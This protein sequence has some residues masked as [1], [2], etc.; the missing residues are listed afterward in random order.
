MEDGRLQD[1]LVSWLV[2]VYKFVNGLMPTYHSSTFV[3]RNSGYDLRGK[4]ITRSSEIEDVYAWSKFLY[5]FR[6]ESL[7]FTN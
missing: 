1:V 3:E 7:E 6:D 5:L 2:L 4:R